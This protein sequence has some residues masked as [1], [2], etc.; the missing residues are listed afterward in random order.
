MKILFLTVLTLYSLLFNGCSNTLKEGKKNTG[1]QRN[2][3]VIEKGTQSAVKT[4]RQLLITSKEEFAKIWEENFSAVYMPPKIPEIDFSK[5]MIVAAWLGEKNTGGFDIEIQ[6]VTTENNV[7]V[8]TFRHIQPG[9][10]CMSSMALEYPFLFAVTEKFPV[11]KSSF[12][13]IKEI[14]ECN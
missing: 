8:I 9:K 3:E 12:H 4:E 6:S 7:L 2:F 5:N 14:R 10:T 11:E 13:I 1:S